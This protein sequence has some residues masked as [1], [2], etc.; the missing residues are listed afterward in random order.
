MSFGSIGYGS[1]AYGGGFPFFTIVFKVKIF[2]L[3]IKQDKTFSLNI[4]QDR[5]FSLEL[6]R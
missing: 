5:T 1:Q 3:N 4:D 6:W 2:S